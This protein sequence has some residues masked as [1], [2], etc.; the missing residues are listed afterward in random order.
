MTSKINVK[1]IVISLIVIVIFGVA[2]LIGV[3]NWKNHK[4]DISNQPVSQ[5]TNGTI[6]WQVYQSSRGFSIKCPIDFDGYSDLPNDTTA[7]QDGLKSGCI[8]KDNGLG[9]IEIIAWTKFTEEIWGKN[10]TF[11]DFLRNEIEIAQRTDSEFQRED[12]FLDN[13]PSVKIIYIENLGENET[14]KIINIYS[15]KDEVMY[16][17]HTV[18]NSAKEKEYSPII[19]EIIS[20]F[21]FSDDKVVDFCGISTFGECSSDADCIIGGCS[22]QVC[23]SKN[24][25]PA[26]T[27]CEYKGCFNTENYGL[28]CKCA[29][30]KCQW[31]K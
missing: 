27:T 21:D 9:A 3:L 5:K 12:I 11:D 24:E 2:I 4:T 20:T 19:E 14:R 23:Q 18:I 8:A 31:A 30:K 10:F 16:H 28:K 13:N 15:E 29:A 22:G 7:F 1:N 17:I 6:D 26:V 25:E